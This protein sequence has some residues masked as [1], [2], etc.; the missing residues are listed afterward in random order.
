MD[1]TTLIGLWHDP[2]SR[3]IVEGFVVFYLFSA[4][5]HAMPAPDDKSG[6]AYRWLYGTLQGVGA[7]FDRLKKPS[8]G[9]QK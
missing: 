7:N 2:A 3:R 1:L 4:A 8:A 5:L 6:V 9:A